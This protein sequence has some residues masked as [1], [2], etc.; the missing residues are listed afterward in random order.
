M[1][2]MLLHAAER[3]DRSP[4]AVRELVVKGQRTAVAVHG[5]PYVVAAEI[6]SLS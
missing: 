4:W 2:A 5:R 3:S 6:A 1:A